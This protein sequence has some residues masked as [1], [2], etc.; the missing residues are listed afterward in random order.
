L[1]E[2]EGG[3]HHWVFQSEGGRW[4]KGKKTFRKRKRGGG[5]SFCDRRWG[6]FGCAKERRVRKERRKQFQSEG[7]RAEKTR[8]GHD[9]GNLIGLAKGN[10]ERQKKERWEGGTFGGEKREKDDR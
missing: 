3:K 2:G 8:F 5:T 4:E 9:G 7:S 10:K 6:G 1:G